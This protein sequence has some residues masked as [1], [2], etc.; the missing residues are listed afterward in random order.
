MARERRRNARQQVQFENGKLRS[1]RFGFEQPVAQFC[2]CSSPQ[3]VQRHVHIVQLTGG[4]S[5]EWKAASRLE[6]NT[7][8]GRLVGRVYYDEFRLHTRNQ[9]APKS[10]TPVGIPPVI[11]PKTVFTKIDDES[12]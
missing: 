12:H 8:D 6:V 7:D 3:C 4:H 9:A 5:E 10:L 1:R 11:D 2:G